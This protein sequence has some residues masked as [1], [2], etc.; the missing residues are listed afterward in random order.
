LEG[1]AGAMHLEEAE[2]AA[3]GRR[4]EELLPQARRIETHLEEMRQG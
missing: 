1:V 3:R 4:L 2:R